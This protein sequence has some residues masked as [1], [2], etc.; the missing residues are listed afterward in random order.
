MLEDIIRE[1]IADKPL[2]I[3]AENFADLLNSM[4]VQEQ[5]KLRA[6]I[7]ENK[8]VSI[9][10]TSQALSD[11]FDKEDRPFYGF[12][13]LYYLK[14]L[15]YKDSLNFLISLARLD[16]R[17]DIVKHIKTKGKAQ[18]RAIYD[19]VK[20]NHRLMVTFYEFLKTDTLA[21]LSNHFIKTIND[22][23]PYYETYIRYLPPQQQKIL[24]YIALSKKPQFGATIAKNCFID[25]KSLSKQ[26]SELTR[27]GL[28]ETIQ[29]R[30]DKRNKLYDIN[31]PLL[32]ISIEVGEHKEG[33]TALF[34][35]FLALFYDV[36]ELENRKTRFSH[37]LAGCDNLFDR[38][39]VQYEIQAIEKALSLKKGSAVRA[40][41]SKLTELIEGSNIQSYIETLNK[42]D[43]AYVQSHKIYSLWAH[44]LFQQAEK[45]EINKK[46]LLLES[47]DKFSL[48]EQN[49]EDMSALN[50]LWGNALGLLA[51]LTEDESLF[52]E[53]MDKLAMAIG[54]YPR[55]AGFYV[56]LAIVQCEAALLVWKE[57]YVLSA[58]GN[59]ETAL[60]LVPGGIR[61]VLVWAVALHYFRRLFEGDRLQSDGFLDAFRCVS[62]EARIS[63]WK[64]LAQMPDPF[65]VTKMSADLYADTRGYI[66]LMRPVLIDWINTIL[67]RNLSALTKDDLEVLRTT[68]GTLKELVPEL[69]VSLSY[70]DVF[71][72]YFLNGNK[73]AVYELPK[74][75]RLFFQKNILQE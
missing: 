43:P 21:K 72:D 4:G 63:A 75:Q 24:R 46:E 48:A 35:D 52:I 33:I 32:R 14:T 29:D 26:L 17:P 28:I 67:A 47:I 3:L 66:D 44:T 62:P 61:A 65:L 31:E 73:N 40:F 30:V 20:G 51:E 45:A 23:K 9:I 41:A 50:N 12:F 22:L 49:Q 27:K 54:S 16:N 58:L 57:E 13:Q 38:K 37:L 64:F 59:I 39:D 1:Y 18:V 5:G 68:A 53:G 7:Y 2:L 74:E 60:A 11:D 56:D 6:W 15:S 25:A 55:I 10:A 36:E 19:L 34:V 71:E 42:M 70:I 69:L 8:R